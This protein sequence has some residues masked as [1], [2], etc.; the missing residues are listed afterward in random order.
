[1]VALLPCLPEYH[2]KPT[3]A[4]TTRHAATSTAFHHG[5]RAA[6][7]ELSCFRAAAYNSGGALNRLAAT[8]TAFFSSCCSSTAAE[9]SLQFSRCAAKVCCAEGSSSPST[10]RPV[11][12]RCSQFIA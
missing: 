9:H 7:G 11:F 6:E 1:M 4:T 2:A 3:A 8:R 10:H 12:S 5:S